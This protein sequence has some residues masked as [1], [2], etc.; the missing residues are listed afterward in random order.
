M[1]GSE[2]QLLRLA[3]GGCHRENPGPVSNLLLTRMSND[4]RRWDGLIAAP[5][6]ITIQ[7]RNN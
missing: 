5:L 1:F 3:A 7:M 4:T 2:T 6:L